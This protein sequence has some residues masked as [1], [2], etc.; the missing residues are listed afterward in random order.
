M[1]LQGQL[2]QQYIIVMIDSGARHNF[3]SSALV[4]KL[5]LLVESTPIF[6]VQ[7][8]DSHCISKSGVYQ[9]I[10]I[11]LENVEIIEDCFPFPL[12][13]VDIISAW[14]GWIL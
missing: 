13:G 9:D 11:D 6:K 1:K 12:G 4:L 8:G 7:L 3:I 2:L 10:Q 5:Q 14:H